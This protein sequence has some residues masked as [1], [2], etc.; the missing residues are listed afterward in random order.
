VITGILASLGIV[1]EMPM[2][3]EV[4]AEIG[5]DDV[6]A[7]YILNFAAITWFCYTLVLELDLISRIS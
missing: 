2:V 7:R 4:F 3:L 6:L 5:F 1:I